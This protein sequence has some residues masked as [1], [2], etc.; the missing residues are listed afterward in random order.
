MKSNQKILTTLNQVLTHKLT[1]INQYFLH[2]RIYKNWGINSLNDA[3]YK[4]SIEDMKLSDKVI[5]RILFLEGLPNLQQLLPLAIGEHTE[6]MINCDLNFQSGQINTI[7]DAIAV[8]EQQ[9]DYVSRELLDNILH[10]DEE[11]LDWLE[12]QQ[13]QINTIGIEKYI[14]A[15]L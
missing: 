15:Q 5:E 1:S 13:Y 6:E 2:A 4:K 12:T 11:H 10:E 8:C 9:R 7:R 3:C 14:Q